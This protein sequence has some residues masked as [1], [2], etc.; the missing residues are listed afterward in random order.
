MGHFLPDRESP[1]Q[2]GADRQT[3]KAVLHC[4][5]QNS[6]LGS[7]FP[8]KEDRSGRFRGPWKR[9]GKSPS[10]VPAVTQV[11][12]GSGCR[13]GARVCVRE[14]MGEG[15]MEGPGMVQ[16]VSSGTQLGPSL[17]QASVSSFAEVE[18]KLSGLPLALTV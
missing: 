18:G 12:R 11:F 8:S 6:E 5:P 15:L 2:A 7:F 14:S 4:L 10:L 13:V 1:G 3:D 17:L 16:G 9:R